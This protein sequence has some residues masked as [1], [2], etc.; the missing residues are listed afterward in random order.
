MKNLVI[1]LTIISLLAAPKVL[2]DE[3]KIQIGGS[4]ELNLSDHSKSQEELHESD[5]A[6]IHENEDEGPNT[7]HPTPTASPIGTP[8]ESPTASP[9]ELPTPS[10]SPEVT[11]GVNVNSNVFDSISEFLKQ[12]VEFIQT[13]GR[14]HEK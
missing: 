10:G 11:A 8:L 2:A 7:P 5:T 3:N 14:P 1:A 13:V 4:T 12:I 9:T 6:K